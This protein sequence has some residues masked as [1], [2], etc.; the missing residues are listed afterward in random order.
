MRA[1]L[2]A[3]LAGV[4]LAQSGPWPTAPAFWP[5]TNRRTA[6]LNGT[7]SFGWAPPNPSAADV[8]YA[9]LATPNTTAVPSSFDIA[10]GRQGPARH[11]L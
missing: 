6:V 10:A 3:G 1:A 11:R 5:Q 7:W 8:P 9:A 2:C 4:A